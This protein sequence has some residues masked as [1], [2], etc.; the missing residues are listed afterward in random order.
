MGCSQQTLHC[1][2]FNTSNN[3]GIS[4]SICFWTYRKPLSRTLLVSKS[5]RSSPLSPPVLP[6]FVATPLIGFAPEKPFCSFRPNARGELSTGELVG[7]KAQPP[8]HAHT[9]YERPALT[10]SF[11]RGMCA[12]LKRL[13]GISVSRAR[14]HGTVFCYLHLCRNSIRLFVKTGHRGM[15]CIDAI[16]QGG[17]TPWHW[18]RWVREWKEVEFKGQQVLRKR[19]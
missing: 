13:F 11:F 18:V 17:T 12:I 8:P 2:E 4:C 9:L 1:T 14:F 5:L 15:K 3:F 16:W 7:A 6:A 10:C 19:G